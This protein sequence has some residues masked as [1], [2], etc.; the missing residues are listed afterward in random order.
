VTLQDVWR[1]LKDVDLEAIR[2]EARQRVDLL[3]VSADGEDAR[4]LAAALRAEGDPAQG[5][6]ASVHPWLHPI[7]AREGLPALEAAPVAAVL[8]SREVEVSG[9][10]AAMRDHLVQHRVPLVTLVVGHWSKAAAVAR[11][12]ESARVAVRGLGNAAG[13]LPGA[14]LATLPEDVRLALA[15]Q[16]PAFRP[17]VAADVVERTAKANAGYAFTTGLAESVP[18]LTAPLALGDMLMLTKNQL[19]MCYRLVLAHGRDG[20]PRA[21][22][23][24]IVGVLGTG[25][26]FRQ[27]ARQL[28]GLIPV[29][30]IVPKVAIAYAGT[31]AIGRSMTLWAAEGRAVTGRAVRRLS[32]EGFASGKAV[33]R[34]LVNQARTAGAALARRRP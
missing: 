1:I 11:H 6:D 29:L 25:L 12:G 27:A 20:E 33:A 4:L 10:L 23:G 31:Y 14:V 18:V 30:G 15:H 8:V 32:K 3:I 34:A 7:A 17:A 9:A 21:L 26:L 22:I 5:P 24:E 16:F 28:V 2:R 13:E 19:V